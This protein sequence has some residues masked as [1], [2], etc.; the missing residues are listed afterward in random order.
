MC[1][2]ASFYTIK[3]RIWQITTC[4]SYFESFASEPGE[5]PRAI[6]MCRP[7]NLDRKLRAGRVAIQ[8]GDAQAKEKCVDEVL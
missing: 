7:C 3:A 4:Y 8:P 1:L 2:R 5:F 6:A